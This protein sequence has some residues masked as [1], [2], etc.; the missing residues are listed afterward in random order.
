M[1]NRIS[2]RGSTTDAII[3]QFQEKLIK[4][5]LKPNQLLPSE[6][7]LSC[8]LET[9]RGSIREAIKILSAFGLVTVKRGKGTYIS[10]SIGNSLIDPFLLT[11]MTSRK[12]TKQLIEFRKAI[13]GQL[14]TFVL[15]N[16]TNDDLER[17]KNQLDEMKQLID[18]GAGNEILIGSDMRFHNAVADAAHNI[19]ISKLYA[20]ILRFFQVY[21][22]RTY[23]SRDNA[24]IAYVY[25]QRI[26]DAI[27]N[28]DS[29]LVL[30]AI[31]DS[32]DEWA[33]RF[34][35]NRKEE[36]RG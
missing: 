24:A 12:D 7:E 6:N 22:K 14:I 36:T 4:G 11:L 27:R 13:E 26:Y 34:D 1:F 25:H 15:K 28:K 8:Q 35:T 20:Y 23:E 17:I 3:D 32:I 33:D 2:D 5:E 19:Y 31:N 30:D 18:A 16:S 9:S 10:D 29:A 21:I